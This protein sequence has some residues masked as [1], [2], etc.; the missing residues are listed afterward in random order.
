MA[1]AAVV[2]WMAVVP[3]ASSGWPSTRSRCPATRTTRSPRCCGTGGTSWWLATGDV[4]AAVRERFHTVL[5]AAGLDEDRARDW[6]VVRELVN[7]MWA[8]TGSDPRHDVREWV[9]RC[10]TIAKAVQD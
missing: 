9:T 4:R 10:V 2:P 5:D 8:L 7:A 3:A 6:V 1:A